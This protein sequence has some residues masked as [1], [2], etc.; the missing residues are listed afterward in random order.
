[1]NNYESSFGS[2]RWAHYVA[3]RLSLMIILVIL[4]VDFLRTDVVVIRCEGGVVVV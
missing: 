2:Y 3:T 1:M 4:D